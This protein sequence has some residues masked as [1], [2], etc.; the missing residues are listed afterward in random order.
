M[1]LVVHLARAR[2]TARAP[3]VAVG[4]FDGVHRGHQRL[5][6]RL[7]RLADALRRPSLLALRRPA[8]GEAVLTTLRQRLDLLAAQGIDRVVLLG[9]HDPVDEAAVAARSAAA[10]LVTGAVAG[11]APCPVERVEPVASEGQVLTSGAIRA[12][13]A[14]GELAAAARALGRWHGVEGRVVHGFHRGAA[15]GIPTANLRVGRQVLPPDG[16]YAVRARVA[17]RALDGVANIGHNPTFGNTA[18][19]VETHLL[20]FSG[21]LYGA[22][23]AIAFVARLRG[24]R[25]FSGVEPLVAQIRADIAAARTL[26][27][28]SGDGV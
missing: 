25:R 4:Q 28:A 17:D 12:W 15:L 27:A 1:E 10:R 20:D 14:G 16:V 24:E 23:L 26:L 22:R 11:G 2:A 13:V 7:R 18:R 9:R 8:P 5:L 21:D 6:A 3:V 19:S